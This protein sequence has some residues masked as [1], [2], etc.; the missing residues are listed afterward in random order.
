MRLETG[1][2]EIADAVTWIEGVTGDKLTGVKSLLG[3][4][5]LMPG[6]FP[7][8]VL[9]TAKPITVKLVITPDTP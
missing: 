3:E 2:A 8:I 9:K 4:I 7:D 5:E 1:N 6:E